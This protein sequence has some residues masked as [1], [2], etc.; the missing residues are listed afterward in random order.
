[1]RVPAFTQDDAHIFCTEDQITSRSLSVTNL[2]LDIYKN[3]GFSDVI[4]KYSDRPEVRVGD[5][6]VWDKSE[7]ALLEAVKA[8]KLEYSINKGEGAFYGPK[9][10]FVLEMQLEEIGNVEHYK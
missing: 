7:A 9:I 4:L 3:L 1:M 8:T 10:E 5:D 2:I 6:K